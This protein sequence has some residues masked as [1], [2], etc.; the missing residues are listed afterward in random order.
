LSY[1]SSSW[2]N[3]AYSKFGPYNIFILFE[4]LNDGVD[5]A[6]FLAET[7]ENALGHVDIVL[8]GASGAVGSGLGLYHDGESW[9]SCFT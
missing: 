1:S 2:K 7:A 5:G 3:V 6:G 4:Y 8:G 9:A